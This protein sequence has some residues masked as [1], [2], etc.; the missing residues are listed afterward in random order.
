MLAGGA[1]D[2]AAQAVEALAPVGVLAG[3]PGPAMVVARD[4]RP[5]AVND[6]AQ[7]LTL[8]FGTQPNLTLHAAVA[9]VLQDQAPAA[10]TVELPDTETP[11]TL[12][13]TVMPQGAAAALLLGRDITL[14]RRLRSALAESRQRYKDLVEA[15]SDF[16]WEIGPEGTFTF[17]SPHGALGYAAAELVGHQPE[18]FAVDGAAAD[19]PLP[20][21]VRRPAE[22]VEFWFRRANGGAAC[23]VAAIVPVYDETGTWRGARGVCRDVTGER[24]RDAILARYRRFERTLGYIIRVIRDEIAPQ[25]MLDTAAEVTARA[26][27]AAGCGI[28]RCVPDGRLAVAA[29]YGTMPDSVTIGD[30][31]GPRMAG[32][33]GCFEAG[34]DDGS[35]LA[36]ATEYR[37]TLNGAICLWRPG[38]SAEPGEESRNLLAA[39]AGQL[40]IALEQIAHQEELERLSQTDALTGLANR[41][42]FAAELE[43]AVARA[44]R[45]ARS[46]ALVYLDLDNFKLVND[47]F[48]HERG[49]QVLCR[50][51][52]ILRHKT[53]RYDQVA[54]LG[55]DEF[56]LW[57]EDTDAAAAR[58]RADDLIAASQSL[59][60]ESPD[61]ARPLGLSIG[62]AI[63]QPGGIEDLST[64]I[65]RA[66][67]AMYQAKH[68]G[69]GRLAVAAAAVARPGDAGLDVGEDR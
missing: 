48:G 36:C 62:A 55:G 6:Q 34:V 23:L 7:R 56:A 68:G 18:D 21:S 31:L 13:V 2:C 12:E 39:I 43:A 61:P 65:A 46:G 64:L 35:V 3:F 27:E 29:G 54:R 30:L 32:R 14:E 58:S 8:L 25:R 52:E 49:D 9:K 17:V 47:R 67:A 57:F 4:G 15:S 45:N 41:R 59:A 50:L 19:M 63:Y 24:E 11:R 60:A 5:L 42:A 16:A 22:G 69:K 33:D 44:R 38:S 10:V 66:D 51:A 53:R 40:G 28:F 37:Q 20:F 1:N 26:C